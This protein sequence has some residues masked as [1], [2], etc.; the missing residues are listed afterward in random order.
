M[1]VYVVIQFYPE[2]NLLLFRFSFELISFKNPTTR[3]SYGQTYGSTKCQPIHGAIR[4]EGT[5][6]LPSKATSLAQ[7]Y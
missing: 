1:D 2:F 4:K 6:K 5:G 3:Y 7:T